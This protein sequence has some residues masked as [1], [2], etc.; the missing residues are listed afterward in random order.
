MHDEHR[1]GQHYIDNRWFIHVHQV[2]LL[3]IRS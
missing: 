3:S 1:P 2:S